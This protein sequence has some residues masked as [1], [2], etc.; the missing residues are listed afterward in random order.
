MKKSTIIA[1]IYGG[2]LGG[3]LAQAGFPIWTW[4]FWSW[5]IPLVF[6][7]FAYAYYSEN[8]Q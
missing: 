7:F 2:M 4:Q 8:N 5:D 6:L 1:G 3:L